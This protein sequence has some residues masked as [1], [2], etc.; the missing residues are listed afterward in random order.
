MQDLPRDVDSLI[1]VHL[2]YEDILSFTQTCRRYR[3]LLSF[4]PLWREKASRDIPTTYLFEDPLLTYNPLLRP[5]YRYLHLL[6]EHCH[7][8][9]K[10]SEDFLPLAKCVKYA[11]CQG[12]PR[13]GIYFMETFSMK[14]TPFLTGLL[15]GHHT[16]LFRE[17]EEAVYDRCK[18]VREMGKS[19][20]VDWDLLP[21]VI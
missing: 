5:A 14:R 13:L 1:A 18:V 2:A 19:G 21:V 15:Q 8:V 10:G 4:T 7:H 11:G 17:K 9:A 16:S 12:D 20:I 3:R 6:G